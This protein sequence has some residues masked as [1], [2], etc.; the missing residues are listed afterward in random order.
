[1][2]SLQLLCWNINQR[3]GI[4]QLDL[5]NMVLEE[6]VKREPDVLVLTEY[7]KKSNHSEFIL[8]LEKEDY[9]AITDNRTT[10]GA[11]EVFIACKKILIK[12]DNPVIETLPTSNEYPNFLALTLT[13]DDKELTVVGTRIKTDSYYN[14]PQEKV[15]QDYKDRNIQLDNLFKYLEKNIQG[16]TIITGDFNNGYYKDNDIVETYLATEK[17]RKYYN[18]PMLKEKAISKGYKLH[19]PK[20]YS[21]GT[22]KL[23]HILT[24]DC[25]VVSINYDWSFTSNPSYRNDT[26]GFPDHAIL[27]AEILSEK[28]GL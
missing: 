24:K 13:V 4:G 2:K 19:T 9:V 15:N 8:E 7:V 26:I 11:N 6:I 5:P 10:T 28:G 22:L 17:G 23:D 3:S 18:Y 25:K 27:T 12:T 16:S 21:C 20:G 1:M 14:S